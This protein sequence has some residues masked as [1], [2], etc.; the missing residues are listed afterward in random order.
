MSRLARILA[1]TSLACTA[2]ALST[3]APAMASTAI[4]IKGTSSDLGAGFTGTLIWQDRTRFTATVKL[5]DLLCDDRQAYFSFLVTPGVGQHWEGKRR[6]NDEGCHN[7]VEWS[8]IAGNDDSGIMAASLIVC[9]DLPTGT[10]A[11]Q[12]YRYDN[13]NIA[14]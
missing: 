3:A 2:V 10:D 1:F 6:F 9:T 14:S 8:G 7:T 12:T 5:D 11:C 4:S 13:P